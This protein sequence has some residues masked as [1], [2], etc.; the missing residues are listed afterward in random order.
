MTPVQCYHNYRTDFSLYVRSCHCVV[1]LWNIWNVSRLWLTSDSV[2][3]L[4]FCIMFQLP[5]HVRQT[6][7]R[8][9]ECSILGN[10]AHNI[11]ICITRVSDPDQRL[12]V[13]KRGVSGDTAQGPRHLASSGTERETHWR[14]AHC[15]GQN[16]RTSALGSITA[17]SNVLPSAADAV[18][19]GAA[20]LHSVMRASD[21]W[22]DVFLLYYTEWIKK[23]T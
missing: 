15:F 11:I 4:L 23:R 20:M 14:T 21:R 18:A 1:L 7:P 3:V 22:H 16:H 17:V 19:I 5:T 6:G 2:A 10:V 13:V 8:Y 9:A 12:R